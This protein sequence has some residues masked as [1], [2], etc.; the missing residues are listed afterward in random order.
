MKKHRLN[1]VL[2]LSIV[3]AVLWIPPTEGQGV[4]PSEPAVAVPNTVT[5][6]AI[7]TSLAPSSLLELATLLQ[8]HAE[9]GQQV[10]MDFAQLRNRALSAFE[11]SDLEVEI[12]LAGSALRHGPVKDPSE[13]PFVFRSGEDAPAPVVGFG[14]RF[15]LRIPRLPDRAE[16]R[17]QLADIL[18]LALELGLVVG[19]GGEETM[20]RYF[21]MMQG[22]EPASKDDGVVRGVLEASDRAEAEAAAQA[23]AMQRARGLAATLAELSGR[24]LG[25]VTSI[26]QVDLGASWRGL[27]EG[28]EVYASLIVTFELR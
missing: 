17:R 18:D 10:M 14:E 28:L 22:R 5:V 20:E 11:E 7:G 21:A 8:C 27:G 12:E 3:C 24:E 6:R 26:D 2:L 23:A 19:E 9:T 13:N 25:R 16:Q 4:V 15:V 1:A